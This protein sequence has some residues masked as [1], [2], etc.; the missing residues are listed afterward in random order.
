MS[1]RNQLF[2]GDNLRVLRESIADVS[3]DLI[4]LDP[5]FNSKRD[6]NLLFK[7]PK[8]SKVS[9]TGKGAG[10]AVSAE[11]PEAEFGYG[12]AQ[13]TAFEDTWHWGQQAEDEF[14]EIL[15]HANTDVAELMRA[16]R[17][18]L[19]ENDMMAYLT[20]MC[21]RLLEL[22]PVLKPTGSLY[23]HCDPTASHYLKVVLDGVFGPERF[24]SEVIWRRYGSHNDSK[25]FGAVHDTI[26]FYTKSNTFKFN[27]QHTAHEVEYIEERFRFADIDG[28]RWAEQNLSSPNPRPNLTYTFTAKNGIVYLPPPNGWKYTPERMSRL[29]LEDRLQTQQLSR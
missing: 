21:I 9:K 23:L 20:A 6:Y 10:G 17:S 4:Y 22:H 16:L 5:P 12:E 18:F 19:K 28:R 24:D 1:E 3:V 8:P 26:L 7:T 29:D 11:E 13:I 2:F 15:Q 27:K 14:R 25:T